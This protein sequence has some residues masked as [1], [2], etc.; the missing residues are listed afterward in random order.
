MFATMVVDGEA[1]S[2]RASSPQSAQGGVT[3]N[4]ENGDNK[5]KCT[6]SNVKSCFKL[7]CAHLFSHIGLCGLVMGY[8]IMGAFIFSY[9][10]AGN[11]K[12]IRN[13]VGSTR[14]QTLDQLY[15][16]TGALDRF[17]GI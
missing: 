15:N 8:S 7:F 9:L 6:A 16:I 1:L 12:E 13:K 17:F 11:E 3:E 10:E 4:A 5:S 2:R 14:N